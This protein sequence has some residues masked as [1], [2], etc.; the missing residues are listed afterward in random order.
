MV[1]AEDEH[2]TARTVP[3]RRV[4]QVLEYSPGLGWAIELEHL[5]HVHQLLMDFE[6]KV[7]TALATMIERISESEL[8]RLKGMKE[9]TEAEAEGRADKVWTLIKIVYVAS[10][11]GAG[12]VPAPYS[13]DLVREER[14]L[15]D[16]SRGNEGV[17][18]YINRFNVQLKK[19]TNLGYEV[20][21]HTARLG[22]IFLL[23]LG[24]EYEDDRLHSRRLGELEYESMT[25]AMAMEKAA[26]W[27]TIRSESSRRIQST[28]TPS[29]L[30]TITADS[31]ATQKSTRTNPTTEPNTKPNT[32]QGNRNQQPMDNKKKPKPNLYCVIHRHGDH[33][34]EDCPL[35]DAKTK[36]IVVAKRDEEWKRRK[37][38]SDV[39]E[40]RR[41][42][43]NISH[44][45]APTLIGLDTMC[46][47]SITPVRDL[48]HT[49]VEG[50]SYRMRG[51][52][53]DY[54][55]DLIVGINPILGPMIYNPKAHYTLLSPATSTKYLRIQVGPG[56][57]TATAVSLRYGL[58]LDF[59]LRDP[60]SEFSGLLICD[61]TK[62]WDRLV[63]KQ[64]LPSLASGES[65]AV[66]SRGDTERLMEVGRAHRVLGHPGLEAMMRMVERSAIRDIPYSLREIKT[67]WAIVKACPA[68][69]VGKS[70][71][72]SHAPKGNSD[73][74]ITTSR[75]VLNLTKPDKVP[76]VCGV[77]L[78]FLRNQVYLISVEIDSRYI[79]CISLM[80]KS[81]SELLNGIK[82]L[83]SH[84]SKWKK[85]VDGYCTISYMLS[86]NEAGVLD[87]EEKYLADNG[88]V[89]RRVPA[90][91]HVGVVERQIRTIKERVESTLVG[92]THILP[93]ECLKYG[94]E[95]VVD[96]INL[97]PRE[98]QPECPYTAF[99]GIKPIYKDVVGPAVGDVVI[100]HDSAS[101][102]G[103][104]GINVGNSLRHPGGIHF[105]SF[106]KRT[107]KVRNRYTST[108]SVDLDP[109][110]PRNKFHAATRSFRSLLNSWT[111]DGTLSEVTLVRPAGEPICGTE[112]G[113]E[114]P[115]D[116][117]SLATEE[118][119]SP[120]VECTREIK[121]A[122][123][124]Q[125]PHSPYL[126]KLPK[127][128]AK[129]HTWKTR[130]SAQAIQQG[131]CSMSWSR[132]IRLFGN[133]ADQAI[134]KEIGQLLEFGVFTPVQPTIIVDN[135]CVSHDLLDRKASGELKARLVMGKDLR[136]QPAD[137]G[138]DS[139]S[140]TLDNKILT[141]MFSVGLQMGH[142]FAVWDVKGAFLKADMIRDDVYVML[143]PQVTQHV[144]KLRDSW[145][146]FVRP[147]GGLLVQVK[148]A[149]YGSS[150]SPALW[151]KELTTTLIDVCEYQQH[152]E[153]SCLFYRQ[154][155][156]DR[157]SFIL[158]HVDDIGI[159]TP[160]D[161]K[162][163]NRVL[164]ILEKKYGDLKKQ[165]GDNVVYIGYEVVK[166]GTCIRLAMTDRI[167]KLARQWN[168]DQ[169]V[170][171]PY[172]NDFLESDLISTSNPSVDSTSYRSLVMSLRYIAMGVMPEC[173]FGCTVL[174]SSQ[175]NPTEADQTKALRLLKYMYGRAEQYVVLTPLGPTPSIYVFCDASYNIS[176][177]N[178]YA[179][180]MV[181]IGECSGA[182]YWRCQCISTVEKSSTDAEI[183]ALSE[184][185]YL[186]QYFQS[187]L[188]VFC[189]KCDITYFCDN[190]PAIDIVSTGRITDVMKRSKSLRIKVA[191]LHLTFQES[192]NKLV[193][194]G[195]EYNWADLMT[196]PLV[197]KVLCRMIES[198]HGVGESSM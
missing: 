134:Q 60:D 63:G 58:Q 50:V 196:K 97:T 55:E 48:L 78:F 11:G 186:G 15:M 146:G 190:Q 192:P 45:E 163:Y 44:R 41:A 110:L 156:E 24:P 8:D 107:I 184:V 86:D 176:N 183:V 76:T 112:S 46:S 165:E 171:T 100:A 10:M 122:D 53:T 9:F 56:C 157:T 179:G 125:T 116:P 33:K 191:S 164:Q 43:C 61:A 158:L 121:N 88:I 135:Y 87:L 57:A 151:N 181:F 27:E 131:V 188:E 12:F 36:A 177:G 93:S 187:I 35:M 115:Y 4:S 149:W 1:C 142:V 38:E 141:L 150:S 84:Y 81:I 92:L 65:A 70:T 80:N 19:M 40:I 130:Y 138:V 194:V 120:P 113:T 133:E 18:A 124:N 22:Y 111:D 137:Y 67:Y 59:I 168:I 129:L 6:N 34:S 83:L 7:T 75:S 16:L 73:R 197:G 198:S 104:L 195:T 101:G 118:D 54:G 193:K 96:S 154:L 39:C 77:D 117:I 66:A 79:Y 69:L 143:T 106:A 140:P 160:P 169:G 64:G 94:V 74:C 178:S 71:G 102:K 20:S 153:M 162:E 144:I 62:V 147:R 98:G 185:E 91:D 2:G 148:K 136:G 42:D 29:T 126:R 175:M 5:R 14:K 37:G 155:E 127:R 17:L 167:R 145:K 103:E 95:H 159:F 172:S 170:R 166:S 114:V 189:G 28:G 26:A 3:S 173:L 72:L 23:N 32:G 119:G 68:C 30:S 128:T 99:T 85:K 105:Y 109:F 47:H 161:G 174:A 90:G 31:N 21:T 132:A 108:E 89:L 49:V 182:V 139:Y 152:S 25:L 180:C 52:D 51:Y 82:R 13:F 123:K